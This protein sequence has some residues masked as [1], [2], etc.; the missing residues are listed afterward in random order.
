MTHSGLPPDGA[1]LVSESVVEALGVAAR[2]DMRLKPAVTG[3]SP[4]WLRRLGLEAKVQLSLLSRR[5][6]V[7]YRGV[8]GDFGLWF[9]VLTLCTARIVG[10]GVVFHHHSY[11]YINTSDFRMRLMT[12]RLA[13]RSHHVLLSEE[14]NE[15]FVDVYGTAARFWTSSVLDNLSSLG[16]LEPPD[17]RERDEPDRVSIA[18]IGNITFDKGLDV[19]VMVVRDLRAAAVD[20]EL[21]LIG[22]V[23]AKEE[24]FLTRENSDVPIVHVGPVAPPDR[25]SE[26]SRA[27]VVL[28]ASRYAHEAQPLVVYEALLSGCY[29]IASD[30]GTISSQLTDDRDGAAIDVADVRERALALLARPHVDARLGIDARMRRQ[31][32]TIARVEW[33]TN[34]RTDWIRALRGGDVV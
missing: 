18:V 20:A 12:G 30:R 34:R 17:L 28:F 5:P 22:T 1:A 14:M 31:E 7:V 19:A 13:R 21:L 10:A 26:Y 27:D 32:R 2:D 33:H 29:V 16:S 23:G 3:R 4:R 25:L 8:S 24:E 9:D 11:R 15:R 6:V